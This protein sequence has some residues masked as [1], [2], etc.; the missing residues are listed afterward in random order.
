MD[1]LSNQLQSLLTIKFV[2][3]LAPGNDLAPY[4][5]AVFDEGRA[6]PQ[7]AAVPVS[8]IDAPTDQAA[9]MALA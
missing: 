5:Q 9:G 3:Q 2:D 8:F 7:L 4:V 1:A 6:N